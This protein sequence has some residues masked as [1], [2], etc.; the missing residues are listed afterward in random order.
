M[1]QVIRPAAV[2]KV[3]EVPNEPIGS[4]LAQ[5]GVALV[6][7]E[8]ILVFLLKLRLPRGGAELRRGLGLPEQLPLA[9]Q[10]V[11]VLDLPVVAPAAKEAEVRAA[12]AAQL[13]LFLQ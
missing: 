12:A 13:A 5:G 9:A 6:G 8:D 2:P 4:Q 1:M 7:E 3:D 10:R 11:G